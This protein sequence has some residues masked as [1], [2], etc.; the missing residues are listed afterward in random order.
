MAHGSPTPLHLIYIVLMTFVDGSRQAIMNPIA[1]AQYEK[2]M[3]DLDPV[4]QLFFVFFVANLLTLIFNRLHSFIVRA[5][6]GGIFLIDYFI[7]FPKLSGI[8][9]QG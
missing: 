4:Q 9:F 1:I 2:G 6:K 3:K 5:C 8:T 7:A